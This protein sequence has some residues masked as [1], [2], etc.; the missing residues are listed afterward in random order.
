MNWLLAH[1]PNCPIHG[2]PNN[3]QCGCAI[4]IILFSMILSMVIGFGVMGINESL[5]E[6]RISTKW[7]FTQAVGMLIGIIGLV[8]IPLV[9]CVLGL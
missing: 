1:V 7:E 9:L 3:E 8:S 2:T 5:I 4:I 6:G